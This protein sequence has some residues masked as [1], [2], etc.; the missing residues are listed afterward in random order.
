MYM[1]RKGKICLLINISFL[2]SRLINALRVSIFIHT[3]IQNINMNDV[4]AERREEKRLLKE[5]II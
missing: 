4:T 5:N 3:A 2:K 1:T